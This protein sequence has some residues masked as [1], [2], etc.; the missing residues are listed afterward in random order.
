MGVPWPPRL[1]RCPEVPQGASPDG[2]VIFFTAPLVHKNTPATTIESPV[3]KSTLAPR[4]ETSRLQRNSAHAGRRSPTIRPR[5]QTVVD[6]NGAD[7]RPQWCRSATAGQV[8]RPRR[9]STG[10]L[11]SFP[12]QPVPRLEP[13]Q[14]LQPV[15]SATNSRSFK[16]RAAK[17]PNYC[18]LV[19]TV[20]GGEKFIPC[21]RA[22]F[23]AYGFHWGST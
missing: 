13:I 8:C 15:I 5:N 18:C 19:D 21:L 16:T 23:L 3:T 20:Q 14:E 4:Q 22:S 6:R 17:R 7:R 12:I 10:V 9:I 2:R 1:K 11:G